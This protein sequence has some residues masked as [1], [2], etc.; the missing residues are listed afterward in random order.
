MP[1]EESAVNIEVEDHSGSVPDVLRA[2]MLGQGWRERQDLAWTLAG[3]SNGL[4]V[5]L[6][7]IND[8]YTWRQVASLGS[9][10][11]E[12]D[13]WIGNACLTSDQEWL[14]SSPWKWCNG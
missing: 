7:R 14:G 1:A 5:L 2:S 6:S 11:V 3:D 12:T 8:G 13:R 10:G 9:S 4:H